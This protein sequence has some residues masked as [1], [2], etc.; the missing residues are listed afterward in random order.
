MAAAGDGDCRVRGREPGGEGIDAGFLFQHVDFRYRHA[1][2]QGY[3]LDHVAQA[4]PQGIA[5]V[6]IHQGTAEAA[7][8]LAAATLERRGPE[9]AGQADDRGRGRAA[10]DEQGH[11]GRQAFRGEGRDA[12]F[13]A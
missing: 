13:Q 10:A 7:R 3:L 4:A 8:N 6:G 2:G 9:Q 5:R 1:R 12:G 11:V